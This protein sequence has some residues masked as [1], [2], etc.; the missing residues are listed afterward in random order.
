MV[1][2]RPVQACPRNPQ[3]RARDI[4]WMAHEWTSD[5]R[6][7]LLGGVVDAIINHAD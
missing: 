1:M 6:R 7:F 3:A 4:A 5:T 2:N